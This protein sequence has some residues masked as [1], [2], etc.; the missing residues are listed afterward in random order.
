[1]VRRNPMVR[2]IKKLPNGHHY[3][4]DLSTTFSAINLHTTNV[5]TRSTAALE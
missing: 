3:N 4:Y 1:M 5:K 2:K